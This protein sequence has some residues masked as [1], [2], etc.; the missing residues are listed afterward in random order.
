MMIHKVRLIIIIIKSVAETKNFQGE[1]F[2]VAPYTVHCV[3]DQN[4][5]IIINNVCYSVYVLF[6]RFV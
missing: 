5:I 4:V 3:H 2:N 1:L 6:C